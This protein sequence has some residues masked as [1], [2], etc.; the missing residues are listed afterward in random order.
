MQSLLWEISM[1]HSSFGFVAL[2]Q[3]SIQRV[4]LGLSL[5]LAGAAAA[6]SEDELVDRV[7]T[8]RLDQE[9]DS[10]GALGGITV[11][12]LGFLYVANFR[13]AVWRVSPEGEAE[14]LTRSL[15]GSSGN[16][17]DSRGDL[18]QSNFF[19]NSITK[20]ART[21][22]VTPFASD[23]LNGPVGLAVDPKDNLY[24]C[25]CSGNTLSKVSPAGVVEPY[26]ESERFACPNGITLG[27]DGYLYVTNFNHHD[28]LKVSPEG[29]VSVFATVPGGAGNSHLAFSKGY[30]YV[31]K[32]IAQQLVR[33]SLAGEVT[34]LA[35]TGQP[36]HDDGPAL[37][38]SFHRPNGIAASAAGD[39]L[40][41]NTL[42]GDYSQPKRSSITIRTVEL[43]TLTKAL[44]EALERGGLGAL[45]QA[46]RRYKSDSVRSKE[47]TVAEMITFGYSFLNRRIVPEARMAFELNAGS[48]PK[49]AAAQ[50]QLG[51]AY[52][53]IGETEKAVAQY[54][55]TLELDPDHQGAKSKLAQLRP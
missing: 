42:V 24:V 43:M 13:D 46:Y 25:N 9:L 6:A 51:E 18:F 52:R 49:V 34:A 3:R 37:E 41:I 15:Y 55:K 11:D 39:L 20:I 21:G 29:E 33:V 26:A 36:G 5:L 14:V 2:G 31:T 45:E 19:G 1:D 22:E 32:I 8:L 53:Y 47:N 17:V 38:A 23:G 27:P 28:I 12:R 10:R 48:Y 40:Y 44:T 4:A 30:F 7:A 54:E 16:V 35:G 50:Y